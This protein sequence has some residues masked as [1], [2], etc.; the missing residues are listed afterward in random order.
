MRVTLRVINR[1]LE[2]AEGIF[3]GVSLTFVS[4]LLFVAVILR[5][6][7]NYAFEW[8]EE[9]VRYVIIWLTFIGGSICARQGA[10]VGVDAFINYLSSHAQKISRLLVDAVSAIFS[11]L[12]TY[13]GFNVTWTTRIFGQVTPAMEIPMYWIF[14]AIP[15]GSALMTIRFI[16]VLWYDYRG[17]EITRL[18][19]AER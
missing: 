2:H 3:V 18:K 17:I 5:Y 8:T 1:I 9:L 6:F 10:H 16:Q 19:S 4:I 11:A 15:V 7:F 12:L 14:M 13:Y